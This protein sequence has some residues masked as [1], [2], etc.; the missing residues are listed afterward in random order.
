MSESLERL[1]ILVAD[2]VE[3][4][5]QADEGMFPSDRIS[6]S[7]RRV[8][9]DNAR[10]P[11]AGM[12]GTCTLFLLE[13][14][15]LAFERH[16]LDARCARASAPLA[17]YPTFHHYAVVRIE[18]AGNPFFFIVDLSA[19]QFFSRPLEALG[20]VPYFVGTREEL[21]RIVGEAQNN[22]LELLRETFVGKR[23]WSLSD[24]DSL[25][26]RDYPFL[27]ES[28]AAL[29]G[30]GRS[31]L[32]TEPLANAWHRTWGQTSRYVPSLSERFDG[33]ARSRLKSLWGTFLEPHLL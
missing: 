24:F 1:K 17:F 5:R 18:D 6:R 25:R 8:Q 15:P 19:A 12:C 7:L 10:T 4:K 21:H 26:Q 32:A 28:E 31:C 14:M 33:T 20:G 3:A 30:A 23:N 22:S 11:M 16:G 13:A 2:I 29:E 9:S 27:Q